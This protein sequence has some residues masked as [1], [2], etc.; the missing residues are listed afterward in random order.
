MNQAQPIVQ[1]TN[2]TQEQT[3]EAEADDEAGD[4][5]DSLNAS[6]KSVVVKG[7]HVTDENGRDLILLDPSA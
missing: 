2:Q 6:I 5:E 4:E 7:Q 3:P 1:A